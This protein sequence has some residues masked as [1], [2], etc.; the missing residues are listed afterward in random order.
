MDPS[1]LGGAQMSDE[2]GSDYISISDEEGNSYE[3][4]HLDTILVD[5][6]YYLAFVPADMDEN[7][8][9]YG[10]IIMKREDDQDGES[11]L[12]VP[13]DD[14]LENVYE[15]FMERLFPDDGEEPDGDDEDEDGDSDDEP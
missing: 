4:E 11:Y 9:H 13:P 14:E 5:G 12:S 1:N 8:E 10:M 7:D 3:L 15:R 6:T 2:Y